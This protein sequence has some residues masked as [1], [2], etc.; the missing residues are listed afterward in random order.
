MRPP[1][2]VRSHAAT[3]TQGRT[4]VV[5]AEPTARHPEIISLKA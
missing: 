1:V 4:K 2:D 5:R 3:Y